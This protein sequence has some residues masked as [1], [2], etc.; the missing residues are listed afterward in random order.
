MCNGVQ[1]VN[2]LVAD[3][4]GHA[5]IRRSHFVR[6][7]RKEWAYTQADL[8]DLLDVTPTYISKIENAKCEVIPSRNLLISLAHIFCL[9]PDYVYDMAGYYDKQKLDAAMAL[10]PE[11]S[12]MVRSLY[13]LIL[14]A[15]ET[16]DALKFCQ[17]LNQSTNRNLQHTQGSV[18][19][20]DQ[21]FEWMKEKD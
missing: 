12:R 13:Q 8:A 18:A 10:H 6:R 16:E 2:G 5:V 7:Q 15:G 9:E 19:G 14:N 20:I 1:R 3:Q 21:Y 11:L 4:L 17:R